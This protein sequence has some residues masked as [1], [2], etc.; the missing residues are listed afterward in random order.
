MSTIKPLG[1]VIP[2]AGPG[3]VEATSIGSAGAVSSAP[4]AGATGAQ[5]VIA[6]LAAGR[7]SPDVAVHRLTEFAVA[8]SGAPATARPAV[9]AKVR[10]LLG[11][12]PTLGVLLGRM[13]AT[14][15]PEG[16]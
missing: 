13:G 2:G 8:Q 11:S 1:A 14:V 16:P 3:A 9:A 10:A 6:D 15:P 5:G 4:A 7:I 12:D